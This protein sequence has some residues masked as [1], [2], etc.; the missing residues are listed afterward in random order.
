MLKGIEEAKTK[1]F[2]SDQLQV[3]AILMTCCTVFLITNVTG[4]YRRQDMAKCTMP[5]G[6]AYEGQTQQETHWSNAVT[7]FVPRLAPGKLRD[8]QYLGD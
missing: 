3:R 6:E 4:I 5:F 2:K 1:G 8:L 7:H